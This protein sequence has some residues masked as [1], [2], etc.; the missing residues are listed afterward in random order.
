MKPDA[1]V[2][3]FCLDVTMRKIPALLVIVA[4]LAAASSAVAYSG[5][6]L[7]VEAVD[8]QTCYRMTELPEGQNWR[9]LGEFN[10]FRQAGQWIWEHR[11][12]VC[13]NSPVFS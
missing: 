13:Q 5:H 8:S 12:G 4:G 10:T 2:P 6:W 9:Q 1:L 3:A 7:V 11:A